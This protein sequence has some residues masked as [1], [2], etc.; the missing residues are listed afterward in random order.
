MTRMNKLSTYKTNVMIT[1]D[2]LTVV[3]VST[4]I[5]E[6]V[7]NTI[8][9]DSGGW[10]T[11][12]TKRK[13]NQTANQYALGFSVFQKAY[14]WFVTLPTGATV[15]FFDGITFDRYSESAAA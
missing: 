5:V 7:G 2:R 11:V 4:P 3:Y 13:M 15:P 1:G 9:L 10:E 14:K 12:T 8:T 6:K